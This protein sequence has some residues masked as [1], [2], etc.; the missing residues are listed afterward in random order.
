MTQSQCTYN[1]DRE[2]A[3]IAYLYDDLEADRA[4]RTAFAA[5]IASCGTCTEEIAALRGVRSQLARWSPPEPALLTAN[6]PT[7]PA[8]VRSP[9]ASWWREVP[10]WAQV[11][12]ALLVVGVSAG[13]AN[14]DIEYDASGLSVRTGWTKA[15]P[16]AR[17][18]PAT[19]AQSDPAP[20]RSDLTALERQLTSTIEA[21]K[22]STPRGGPP[23]QPARGASADDD[24]VR[25]VRALIEASEK[26]QQNELALR[27]AE[28]LRDVHAMRQA[29]LVKIDRTLGEVR[30]DLGVQVMRDRQ[31][32]NTLL[33]RT[34]GR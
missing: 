8:A 25:R 32:L 29:D 16:E 19:A 2:Q 21:A 20:W 5:H 24:V 12:A 28:V 15:A 26:R 18:A 13:I 9:K 1:G 11:A 22:V 3:L 10:V 27:V 14:L 17:T 31:K 34:A 30:N 6:T 4:G 7:P 23:L 33:V